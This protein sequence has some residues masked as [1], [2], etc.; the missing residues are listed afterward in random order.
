MARLVPSDNDLA[1]RVVDQVLRDRLTEPGLLAEEIIDALREQFK[2]E[3]RLRIRPMTT[4]EIKRMQALRAEGKT[5]GEIAQIVG[6]S[7][8]VVHVNLSPERQERR[9]LYNAKRNR[10]K[11]VARG[12]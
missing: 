4:S 12:S 8:N 2:F 1:V 6:R 11:K 9:R 10:A 3:R 5:I 7:W